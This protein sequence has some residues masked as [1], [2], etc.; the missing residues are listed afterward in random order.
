MPILL[1]ILPRVAALTQ[2]HGPMSA[3][4]MAAALAEE[5]VVLS[6]E[7]ARRAQRRAGVDG[8]RKAPRR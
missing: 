3:Y 7:T 1:T 6:A 4:A 5:G 2:R 8:A